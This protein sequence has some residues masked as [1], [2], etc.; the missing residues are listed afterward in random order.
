MYCLTLAILSA[1]VTPAQSITGTEVLVTPTALGY[2]TASTA[3]ANIAFKF[4]LQGG[5]GLATTNYVDFK[6]TTAAGV[7]VFSASGTGQTCTATKGGVIFVNPTD[8]TAE[9]VDQQ[10]VRFRAASANFGVG[11]YVF[12]CTTALAAITAYNTP[13]QFDM[14]HSPTSTSVAAVTNIDGWQPGQYLTWTFANSPSS[15]TP[16]AGGTPTFFYFE[17]TNIGPIDITPSQPLYIEGTQAWLDSSGGASMT[18]TSHVNMEVVGVGGPAN[19]PTCV[20]TGA[21]TILTCT[22]QS[23]G[24]ADE[25]QSSSVSSSNVFRIT[26]QSKLLYHSATS[27]QQDF[28][29]RITA[30]STTKGGQVPAADGLVHSGN[31]NGAYTTSTGGGGASGDPVTYF[32]DTRT[33]FNLPIG[34]LTPIIKVPNFHLLAS[35]FEGSQE[36]EQWIDR[37]LVTT[38]SGEKIADIAIKKDLLDFDRRGTPWNAFETLDVVMWDDRRLTPLPIFPP[39]DAY[40]PHAV[41]ITITFARPTACP[42][43]NATVRIPC[44]ECAHIASEYMK[45]LICAASA[46]EYFKGGYG[47]YKY[48]HLD[49]D[50]FDV[51]FRQEV[52][53]QYGGVMPEIWGLVPMSNATRDMIKSQ[54]L[55]S[56]DLM[57]QV[58]TQVDNINVSVS[59]YGEIGECSVSSCKA[60][61]ST[62]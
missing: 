28:T 19:P 61:T 11:I 26:I 30:S 33:E 43:N 39:L 23:G 56:P 20:I 35:A 5:E 54:E 55:I 38:P 25:I 31:I 59:T 14:F 2:C 47:S 52:K 48:A 7:N 45:L 29:L 34:T 18:G 1:L 42:M 12:T 53:S 37:L 49:F 50:V 40:F 21:N 27:T 6:V 3:V 51:E 41:G 24:T 46:H 9:Y 58:P 10:T 4:E 8:F 62:I 22:P 17:T 60:Q 57:G 15:S 36:G 16:G 32:G 13:V 44:R